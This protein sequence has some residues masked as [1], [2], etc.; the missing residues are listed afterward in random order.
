MTK[1][2]DKEKTVATSRMGNDHNQENKNDPDKEKCKERMIT[3]KKR[4]NYKTIAMMRR[5]RRIAT[6]II[7][8]ISMRKREKEKTI[9]TIR[10]ESINKR[11]RVG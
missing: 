5:R 6:R 3:T 11:E 1:R 4:K 7:E 2:R 8:A 9:T 10:S